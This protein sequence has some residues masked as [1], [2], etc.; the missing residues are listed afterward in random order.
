LIP[1][2]HRLTSGA[3]DHVIAEKHG[4]QTSSENLANSCIRC[5]QHKGTD[6]SSI[7]P[8]TGEI[9]RL[10]NPRTDQWFEHFELVGAEVRG[11]TA[12]GRATVRMLQLNRK[13]RVQE[14]FLLLEAGFLD[15]P[16]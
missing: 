13:T 16:K 14:R 8:V 6:L 4:G 5:N 1:D 9:V 2:S 15:L 11:L 12:S 7:D 10:Y 3:I